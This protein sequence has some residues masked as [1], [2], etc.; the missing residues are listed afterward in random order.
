MRWR[1]RESEKEEGEEGEMENLFSESTY[2][3]NSS[4]LA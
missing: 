4:L 1:S 2:A 3:L